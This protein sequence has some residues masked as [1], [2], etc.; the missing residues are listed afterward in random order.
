VRGQLGLGQ[1]GLPLAQRELLLG[2]RQLRLGA[3]PHQL[4]GLLRGVQALV[5]EIAGE[6]LVLQLEDLVAAAHA[7]AVLG[8]P[9]DLHL[10]GRRARDDH[11]LRPR[12]PQL[13]GEQRPRARGGLGVGSGGGRGGR[14]RG[15]AGERGR[16]RDRRRG[17][18]RTRRLAAT[19]EDQRRHE[20]DER[21]CPPGG[22]SPGP[23]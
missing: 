6:L 13:A 2:H 1:L 16:S 18:P 9:A 15:P 21:R 22:A 11:V 5:L 14:G 7:G 3:Q 17:R 20:G 4:L 19:A 12:R 8:H 23:K 10:P